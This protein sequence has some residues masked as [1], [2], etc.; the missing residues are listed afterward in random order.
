MSD[1]TIP[2]PDRIRHV[3][4]GFGWVDHRFVRDGHIRGLSREALALYLFLITV[5]NEDGISWYS[6]EK[7]CLLIGLESADLSSARRELSSLSLLS[8]SRPVYQIL[9][10]P[11]PA[12][13]VARTASSDDDVLSRRCGGI[14]SIGDIFAMMAEGGT[15]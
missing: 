5:A 3:P 10:L 4:A 8:Y 7:L 9:E 12:P 2:R 15:K 1:K 11:Q 13:T 6:E 14:R